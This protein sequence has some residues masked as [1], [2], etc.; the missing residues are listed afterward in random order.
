MK[1]V[2]NTYHL[3]DKCKICTKIDVK[4]RAINKE[5]ERIIR[6]RREGASGRI[7]SIEKSQE[8]I[9]Q[10]E[11][12]IIRLEGERDLKKQTLW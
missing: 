2:M 1:L 8:Q 10:L 11:M 5:N 9:G 7:H 3:A 4:S 6:W 12:E